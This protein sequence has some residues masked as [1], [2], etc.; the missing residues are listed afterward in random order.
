MSTA[1]KTFLL[2]RKAFYLKE[3]SELKDK[4]YTLKLYISQIDAKIKNEEEKE[5]KND[6]GIYPLCNKTT[7]TSNGMFRVHNYYGGIDPIYIG[8]KVEEDIVKRDKE[9]LENV[10]K[11][12]K[13]FNPD[14]SSEEGLEEISKAKEFFRKF[15]ESYYSTYT[16]KDPEPFSAPSGSDFDVDKDSIKEDM[17][18]QEET[19]IGD[20]GIYEERKIQEQIREE[21]NE[22]ENKLL[23][24]LD[25]IATT[26]EKYVKKIKS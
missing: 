19:Y 13:F 6:L 8:S 20:L 11:L 16:S 23:S 17:G 10:E 18:K 26:F 14:L 25:R 7:I 2:N 15:L 5:S 21:E 9:Y 22:K 24:I 3:L 4:E 1:A 12:T